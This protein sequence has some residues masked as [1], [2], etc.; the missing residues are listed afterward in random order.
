M[1]DVKLCSIR[2]QPPLCAEL[3]PPVAVAV[4]REAVAIRACSNRG[5]S[6]AD[7]AS[8][9]TLSSTAMTEM[10]STQVAAETADLGKANEAL[11]AKVNNLSTPS[12]VILAAIEAE[13]VSL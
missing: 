2:C 8:V 12:P 3:P 10:I 1:G 13:V 5:M 11:V 7:T 9:S 6:Y 4:A